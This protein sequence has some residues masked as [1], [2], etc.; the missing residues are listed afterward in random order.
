[1]RFARG[2]FL[3]KFGQILIRNSFKYLKK[4]EGCTISSVKYLGIGN[5][6]SNVLGI[7][8]GTIILQI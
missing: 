3:S 7:F 4:L 8:P 2:H 1:M 5:N 6:N